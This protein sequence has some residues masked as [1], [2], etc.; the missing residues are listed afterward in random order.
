MYISDMQRVL[1]NPCKRII[2]LREGVATPRMG[3]SAEEEVI[4]VA[5][6]LN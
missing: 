1:D 6:I 4:L 5:V 3:T 2:G